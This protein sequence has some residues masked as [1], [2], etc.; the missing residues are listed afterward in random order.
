MELHDPASAQ[1]GRLLGVGAIVVTSILWG[2][3]GTAATFAP[4]VGPLAIGSAAL[5]LGG[6]LQAL[7]ALPSIRREWSA[8]ATHRRVLAVGALAVLVYPLAFYSSM[9]LAGVAIGSVV[10]LALAPI[11]S[12]AI[13]AAVDRRSPGAR[14]LACALAGALGAGLLV[15]SREGAAAGSTASTL[16][17]AVLGV[18][19][20]ATYAAYTW[21]AR[22]L[23]MG[24]VGR[25][26]AMGA[27]F[28]CGGLLLMPVLL[29][30]GAPILAT[31][32]SFVVAAYMCL[33]PMLL[34]YVLFG[35]GLTRVPAST[36]TTITLLEPAVAA[37][38]AVLAV[39]ERLT[40]AGWV[41][42]AVLGGVLVAVSLGGAD[43]RPFG[44]GTRS[45]G[46]G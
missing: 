14:W 18:L 3:T 6:L 45:G 39:G 10:S 2:T 33:V 22:R 28:G 25:G 17:G 16:L 44:R 46:R 7:V 1:R 32:T 4:G 41:G 15:T 5:G 21:S 23:V 35:V 11:A 8:I 43:E 29:A 38:L 27:V 30:T 42:L 9:H 13:E 20:A 37:V 24:G 34:G 12:G 40:P 26:A 19:A 31:R 36:A